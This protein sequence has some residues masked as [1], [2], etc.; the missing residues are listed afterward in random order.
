MKGEQLSKTGE[1]DKAAGLYESIIEETDI[2]WAYL[3]LGKVRCFQKKYE[4]A[5]EVFEGLIKENA[6][7]VAAYDWLAKCYEETGELKKPRKC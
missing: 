1:Y 3:A 4:E 6:S 2:P 7:N 5:I